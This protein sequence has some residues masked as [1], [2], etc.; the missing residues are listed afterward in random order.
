MGEQKRPIEVEVRATLVIDPRDEGVI[1][2]W[3]IEQLRYR[4][5][6]VCE[7]SAA[8]V[9]PEGIRATVRFISPTP[10]DLKAAQLGSDALGSL[11]VAPLPDEPHVQVVARWRYGVASLAEVLALRRVL[12]AVSGWQPSRAI[13]LARSSPGWVL[14]VGHP[15]RAGRV[16]VEAQRAGLVAV[17]EPFVPPAGE[18]P[19]QFGAY[20]GC[21]VPLSWWPR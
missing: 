11:F 21:E 2:A 20:W 9:L 14:M 19:E 1:A 13:G 12:P 8:L 6:D 4:V 3:D 7:S 17:A 18:S 16:V 10:F 15:A 5:F